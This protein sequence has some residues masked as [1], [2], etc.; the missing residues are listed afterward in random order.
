[1]LN[2]VSGWKKSRSSDWNIPKLKRHSR[3]SENSRLIEI[4]HLAHIQEN[5]QSHRQGELQR[6]QLRIET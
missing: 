5:T 1:M 2:S 3:R 6:N 4:I